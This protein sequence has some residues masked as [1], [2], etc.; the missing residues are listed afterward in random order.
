M[1]FPCPSTES[2][3]PFHTSSVKP[4]LAYPLFTH[5]TVTT[6]PSCP[7]SS[8][9]IVPR[10]LLI[11]L[12]HISLKYLSIFWWR[13][14]RRTFSESTFYPKKL[15][16]SYGNTIYYRRPI[17]VPLSIPFIKLTTPTFRVKTKL[18]WQQLSS[19]YKNKNTHTTTLTP[20]ILSPFVYTKLRRPIILGYITA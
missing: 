10:L 9:L 3:S 2:D 18:F 14:P 12:R 5:P 1:S 4:S 15:R 6:L 13:I 7:L 8:R 17:S 16:F 19:P 11:S 20:T